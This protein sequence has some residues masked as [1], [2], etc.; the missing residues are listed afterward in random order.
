MKGFNVVM[1]LNIHLNAIM[2]IVCQWWQG[3]MGGFLCRPSPAGGKSL[4][5][6]WRVMV[7]YDGFELL[8]TLNCGATTIKQVTR[9]PILFPVILSPIIGLIT[10]FVFG[11]IGSFLVDFYGLNRTAIA[12]FLSTVLISILF[13]QALLIYLIINFLIAFRKK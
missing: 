2:Q 8:Y 9:R 3:P 7:I 5:R 12:I 1:L 13:W 11:R 4:D 6:L 10:F